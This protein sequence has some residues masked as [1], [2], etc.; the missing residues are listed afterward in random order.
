MTDDTSRVLAA[1]RAGLE[2]GVAVRA[3][4]AEAPAVCPAAV[5]MPARCVPALSAA[6]DTLL[7]E[8]TQAIRLTARRFAQLRRLSAQAEAAMTALGYALTDMEAGDGAPRAVLLR[9]RGYTDG[10][11]MTDG[12]IAEVF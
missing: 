5:L 10:E 7:T 6:E 1:L 11:T 2:A 3:A 4:W 9:F 12:G 8:V